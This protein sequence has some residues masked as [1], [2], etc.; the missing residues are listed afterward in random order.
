V[1]GR[2]L[3]DRLQPLGPVDQQGR[4]VGGQDPGHR[5][6]EGDAALDLDRSAQAFGEHRAQGLALVHGNHRERS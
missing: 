5:Q 4:C 2:R 6:L 1:P 3:E